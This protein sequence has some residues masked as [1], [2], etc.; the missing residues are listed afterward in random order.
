M[1]EKRDRVE[2]AMNA[3]RAA[4]EEG[5]VLVAEPLS[6]CVEGPRQAELGNDDQRV[7]VEIVRKALQAPGRSLKMPVLKVY[8]GWQDA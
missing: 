6:A 5:I 7:G 4:V 2:D 8:R 1:K 3:T